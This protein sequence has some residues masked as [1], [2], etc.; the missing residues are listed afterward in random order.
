M[1][2]PVPKRSTQ[3]RRRNKVDIDTVRLDDVVEV[4]PLMLEDCPQIVT[5]F[6]DSL[7]R[8]GQAR[9]YEPSDWQRARLMCWHLA[10]MLRA[11]KPSSVMYTA[12]QKDM[13]A[14]LVSEGD[15]RR[16]RM[17]VERKP[18]DTSLEDAR[19]AQMNRYRNAVAG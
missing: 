3:R 11:N 15:R 5:D 8:S 1:P 12:L 2:G 4:P 19:V 7:R 9:Y 10:Y 14:L 6:Y 17:E 16:V 18:A 13:E